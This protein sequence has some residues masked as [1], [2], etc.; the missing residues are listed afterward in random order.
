MVTAVLMWLVMSKITKYISCK[1]MTV[2]YLKGL[3]L[4]NKVILRKHS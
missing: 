1:V 2:V 3:V 4:I